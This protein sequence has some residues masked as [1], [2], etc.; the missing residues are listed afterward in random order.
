MQ[1]VPTKLWVYWSRLG[2]KIYQV[3]DLKQAQDFVEDLNYRSGTLAF[4]STQGVPT[5]DNF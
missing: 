2:L 1:Q 5:Y 3:T 4:L